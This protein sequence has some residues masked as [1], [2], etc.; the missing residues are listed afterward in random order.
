MLTYVQK[1]DIRRHLDY[2]VAGLLQASPAGGTVASAFVG[3]RFFQAY[4][5]LEWKMNNLNPDEEARITGASYAAVLL[6]GPN[7]NV[8]DTVSIT[9]SGG[10]LTA[11]VVLTATM[12][13]FPANTAALPFLANA[14]AVAAQQNT[15]LQAA[16]IVCVTPYGTGPFNQN[17]LPLTE[18][19]F[20]SPIGFTVSNPTGSGAIIPQITSPGGILPPTSVVDG[21]N[22]F[23]GYLGILNALESAWPA[24]SQNM[25]TNAAGPWTARSTESSQRLSL[26]A[27]WQNRFSRFLEIPIYTGPD[28]RRKDYTPTS[29]YA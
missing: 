19:A 4:G 26:Y 6:V 25:D 3:Y 13:P 11:P 14:L 1:S 10:N 22:T 2:P 28:S 23:N 17:E 16:G 12:P 27:N 5:R 29:R 21:I 15:A 18:I 7:P 24:S 20:T 9:L 8:G